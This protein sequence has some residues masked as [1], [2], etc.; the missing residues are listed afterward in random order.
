MGACLNALETIKKILGG[1]TDRTNEIFKDI[2]GSGRIK[3]FR[4]LFWLF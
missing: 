2:K 3:S 1:G 4:N